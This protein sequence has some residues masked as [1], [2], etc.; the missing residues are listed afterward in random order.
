MTG[1]LPSA[2]KD[3]YRLGDIKLRGTN[4]NLNGY[5]LSSGSLKAGDLYSENVSLK[6]TEVGAATVQVLG[7]LSAN[8]IGNG[9]VY[10]LNQPSG[11]SR[12]GEGSGKILKAD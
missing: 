12:T 3:S 2:V 7:N 5:I 11:I 9:N 4:G 1:T 6:L 10:Y 8:I